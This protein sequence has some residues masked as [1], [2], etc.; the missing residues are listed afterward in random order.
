MA[1]PVVIAIAKAIIDYGI[2]VH[3]ASVMNAAQ[4]EYYQTLEEAEL[5]QLA[6][7][8]SNAFPQ[9]PYHEWIILLRAIR[10]YGVSYPIP[11]A[12]FDPVLQAPFVEPVDY[13]VCDIISKDYVQ[14]GHRIEDQL[15]IP[16]WETDIII[17]NAIDEGYSF[18]QAYEKTNLPNPPLAMHGCL[19]DVYREKF[20]WTDTGKLEFAA[21]IQ[22]CR[23]FMDC[24]KEF[25]G[26]KAEWP[27][28][29]A[30][31]DIRMRIGPGLWAPSFDEQICIRNNFPLC[32][33]DIYRAYDE[34]GAHA[35]IPQFPGAMAYIA[36]VLKK[37]PNANLYRIIKSAYQIYLLYF[38]NPLVLPRTLTPE[39]IRLR[40]EALRALEEE[41]K[42][43]PV[44]IYALIAF[45]V[46][47]LIMRK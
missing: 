42:K 32:N 16:L 47:A 22:T 20:L 10:R 26:G 1:G 7:T 33:G 6:I 37:K 28:N 36:S 46:G 13:S 27:W 24:Y 19:Y 11:P 45:G 9:Y 29:P 44:W 43:T 12:E 15:Y 3:A 31:R 8:L 5:Y 34:C 18:D 23:G 30:E 35:I 21:P 25:T 17:R 4:F 41:Y 14:G 39:E 2:N 40:K 38:I